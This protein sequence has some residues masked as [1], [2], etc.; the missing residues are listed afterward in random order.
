MR[1]EFVRVVELQ[2]LADGHR[3]DCTVTQEADGKFAYDED[4]QI[5][6]PFVVFETDG[7]VAKFIGL[8]DRRVVA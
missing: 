5:V 4:V 1:N 3:F 2:S 6:G 7:L 8:R